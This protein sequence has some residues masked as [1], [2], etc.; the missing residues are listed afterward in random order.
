MLVNRSVLISQ[1]LA[2]NGVSP[3]ASYSVIVFLESPITCLLG[4]DLW[5][6]FCDKVKTSV[7][8]SLS[9]FN[10]NSSSSLKKK[11]RKKKTEL[12]VS[13]WF[14]V[15]ARH[16]FR[17][18]WFSYCI[19]LS[20]NVLVCLKTDTHWSCAS[21]VVWWRGWQEFLADRLNLIDWQHDLDHW[22]L[23]S[24]IAGKACRFL[25]SQVSFVTVYNNDLWFTDLWPVFWVRVER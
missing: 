13:I 10:P 24:G 12:W 22:S 5:C 25:A 3:A 21:R 8:P 2:I 16:L 1:L 14:C 15:Q 17:F 11:I 19:N 4:L 7:T 20:A 23:L 18:S 6:M 9:S